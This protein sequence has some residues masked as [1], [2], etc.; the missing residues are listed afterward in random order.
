M[1]MSWRPKTASALLTFGLARRVVNVLSTYVGATLTKMT[2]VPNSS[3]GIQ[4]TSSLRTRPSHLR[5]LTGRDSNRPHVVDSRPRIDHTWLIAVWTRHMVESRDE[6][7]SDAFRGGPSR[8]CGIRLVGSGLN[9]IQVDYLPCRNAISSSLASQIQ[10]VRRPLTFEKWGSF[11]TT[12][13]SRRRAV[14]AITQS[15]I[16]RS[17]WTHRRAPASRASPMSRGTTSRPACS[18]ACS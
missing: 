14:A 8:L 6:D 1:A 17:L 3:L 18:R 4:N 13:P 15:A 2:L 16:G 12:R 10:I 7:R 5:L 9:A 11:V